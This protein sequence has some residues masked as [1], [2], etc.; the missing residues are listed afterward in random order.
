MSGNMRR[1]SF[2]GRRALTIIL[3][4]GMNSGRKREANP[5]KVRCESETDKKGVRIQQVNGIESPRANS[6]E[7]G[8]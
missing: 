8:A 4:K 6:Q 3:T 5:F 1:R 2:F 7:R